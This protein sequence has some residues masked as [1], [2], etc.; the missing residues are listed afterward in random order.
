MLLELP[1]SYGLC[2]VYIHLWGLL[3]W[4]AFTGLVLIT[5]LILLLSFGFTATGRGH[6]LGKRRLNFRFGFV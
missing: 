3:G 1:D 6:S 2:L 4:F 5:T